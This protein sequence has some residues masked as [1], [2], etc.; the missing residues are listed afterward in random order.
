[1]AERDLRG[2]VVAVVGASGGLGR[3]IVEALAARG[4]AVVLAGPHPDRLAEVAPTPDALAVGLDIRRPQAGDDLV[5]AVSARF[6]RL[7]GLVVAS[8]VVAFGTLADTDDDVVE[9]LFLTNVLGPLWMV[10]RATPLLTASKGFVVLVSA[11]LAEQPLPGMAAYGASK[12]ALSSAAGA[13]TR[14]LRRQGIGVVDVRPPHTETG[15]ADRAI[16][17][18]APRLP[19]GLDP[20]T[21]GER[22]VAAVEAGAREVPAAGFGPSD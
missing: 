22:I 7:D 8:G 9:E 13:L 15:L 21:V 11:V 18:T 19:T 16:G 14:E 4:A 17:G 1:M 6:G 20:R 12:A 3:P 10:K 5:D 2:A